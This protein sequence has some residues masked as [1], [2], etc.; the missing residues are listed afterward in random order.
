MQ[1]RPWSRTTGGPDPVSVQASL[2]ST[3]F[4]SGSLGRRDGLQTLVRDGLAAF[5]REPVRA[6]GQARLGP[7]DRGEILAEIV[8]PSL[9][10]LVLVEIGRLVRRILFIRQLTGVLMPEPGQRALDPRALGGEKFACPIRIHRADVT[11]RT[12]LGAEAE[13]S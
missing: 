9:V 1:V 12:V 7:L 8:G 13:A 3:F 11:G 10:E 5:D 6:R 4:F 2:A